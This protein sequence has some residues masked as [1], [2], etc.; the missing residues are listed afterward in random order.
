MFA[1]TVGNYHHSTRLIPETP[2]FNI[3]LQR[4]VYIDV[5]LFS[6]G[7]IYMEKDR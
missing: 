1:E 6:F 2:K 4:C 5:C 3:V 7:V